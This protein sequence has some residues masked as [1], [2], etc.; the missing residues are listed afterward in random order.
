LALHALLE[1]AEIEEV[2]GFEPADPCALT[3]LGVS[4]V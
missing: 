4:G 2:A 1:G 3:D